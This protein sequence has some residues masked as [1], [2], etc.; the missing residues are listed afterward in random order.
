MLT[1]NIQN[2]QNAIATATAGLAKSRDLTT[3]KVEAHNAKIAKLAEKAKNARN[4]LYAAEAALLAA[5]DGEAAILADRERI[6]AKKAATLTKRQDALADKLAREA[7]ADAKRGQAARRADA[8]ERPDVNR[9]REERV[10][11]K[12]AAVVRSRMMDDSAKWNAE[13]VRLA[14]ECMAALVA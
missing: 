8:T 11:I 10:T 6:D 14:E 1:S 9:E 13:A 4:A 12:G 7:A 2:A 5:I 3:R